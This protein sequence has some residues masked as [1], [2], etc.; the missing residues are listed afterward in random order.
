MKTTNQ[1]TQ[2]QQAR[3]MFASI[4]EATR[5]INRSAREHKLEDLEEAIAI[6]G[7]I[8]QD[9]SPISNQ[10]KLAERK[11]FMSVVQELDHETQLLIEEH[12]QEIIDSLKVISKQKMVLNY[13]R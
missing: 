3:E 12:K 2:E 6:R 5:I 7:K 10:L 4:V 8:L 13:S 11:E 1:N 9:A